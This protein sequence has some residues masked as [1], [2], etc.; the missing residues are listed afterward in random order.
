MGT[1]ISKEEKNNS[2]NT[3]HE[4]K[5][6]QSTTDI[7]KIPSVFVNKDLLNFVLTE[8]RVTKYDRKVYEVHG[9]FYAEDE[10]NEFGDITPFKIY[11]QK[12]SDSK[13]L[14]M[15]IKM[16]NHGYIINSTIFLSIVNFHTLMV[17]IDDY[18]N[19]FVCDKIIWKEDEDDHIRSDEH[20]INLDKYPPLEKFGLS[21]MRLKNEH[22][23]CGVCNTVLHKNYLETHSEEGSHC[24]KQTI[25]SLNAT[26]T[27]KRHKKVRRKKK[28]GGKQNNDNA[29]DIK[30]TD[31]NLI[32]NNVMSIM[33][34][35]N[36]DKKINNDEKTTRAE[37][38]NN[39]TNN[40]EAA[41]TEI[42][43]NDDNANG[44]NDCAMNKEINNDESYENTL[45]KSTVS[46]K[47]LNNVLEMSYYT[48]NMICISKASKSNTFYC[49]ACKIA[50]QLEKIEN[51]IVEKVHDDNLKRFKINH[52]YKDHVI[53]Q[54]DK[55]SH[56]GTCN[57]V[58]FLSG[59]D[60]HISKMHKSKKAVAEPLSSPES[61]L[62]NKQILKDKCLLS[63]T[64]NKNN[65]KTNIDANINDKI[66]AIINERHFVILCGYK[67]NISLM[68]LHV[69][70]R[71]VNGFYC[72]LCRI[73]FPFFYI[74]VHICNPM[75][76]LLLKSV[77]ALPQY[78]YNYIRLVNGLPHCGICHCVVQ[79]DLL[80]HHIQNAGHVILTNLALGK[81]MLQNFPTAAG[82]ETRLNNDVANINNDV[83]NINNDNEN[84]NND[85]GNI[86]N[87]VANINNDDENINNDV[88][89]INNDVDNINNVVANKIDDISKP[90]S[91][92]LNDNNNVSNMNNDATTINNDEIE[93]TQT[94]S[95]DDGNIVNDVLV[96]K[97]N[98]SGLAE[99][100]SNKDSKIDSADV[101]EIEVALGRS[102]ITLMSYH[103]MVPKGDGDRH[104]FLCRKNVEYDQVKNHI[105]SDLHMEN[106]KKHKFL[107]EYGENFIR[108]NTLLYHCAF[109]NTILRRADFKAHLNCT[110]H[111]NNKKLMSS[112]KKKQ[113]KKYICKAYE[114]QKECI[115]FREKETDIKVTLSLCKT[116]D[117]SIEIL[118]QNEFDLPRKNDIETKSNASS[119]TT[120]TEP[121]ENLKKTQTYSSCLKA[122]MFTD[123][124]STSATNVN[125]NENSKQSGSNLSC[126]KESQII[127]DSLS[128]FITD[129]ESN[130]CEKVSE[131]VDSLS[132]STTDDSK[133]NLKHS[134]FKLSRQQFD[135]ED[136]MSTSNKKLKQKESLF[137]HKNEP[138]VN[139]SV[140]SSTQLMSNVNFKK[141]K[142]VI[143]KGYNLK[144]ALNWEAWHAI[145]KVRNTYQRCSHKCLLCR[146]LL[147]NK[148]DIY[149][150]VNSVKHTCNL[151]LPFMTEY[152]PDLLRQIDESTI[153]C[154]VC[155]TEIYNI[156]NINCHVSGQ[157]HKN[158]FKMFLTNS[159]DKTGCLEEV[160]VL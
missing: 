140:S 78:G 110:S 28:K 89:N 123:S 44:N 115:F 160:L 43:N 120:N 31:T 144:Y 131:I 148:K 147:N 96:E 101:F 56:C 60:E 82:I 93:N 142:L 104:C 20:Q 90:S 2:S 107:I 121:N 21:I 95:V 117:E 12:V 152:F 48:W 41:L 128:T 62:G 8:Q 11:A 9:Q 141:R 58:H 10:Y 30:N 42:E 139:A 103:A 13:K 151:R 3:D 34:I 19:C 111:E 155:N 59:I 145:S 1:E 124:L 22:G 55:F 154:V 84:I 36:D 6:I 61:H 25:A 118:K 149:N 32:N 119:S 76:L 70:F 158:N 86:N 125:S 49:M 71:Y 29:T 146:D 80:L 94:S 87:D 98:E 81:A 65:E 97:T 47:V 39:D 106:M 129:V 38:N 66:N 137:F 54:D 26:R 112:F 4:T 72:G 57:T 79:P 113:L 14:D 37:M 116:N 74:Q 130:E 85:V 108:Q 46:V 68:S 40:E 126:E 143:L 157:N 153:N 51:H 138:E 135:I 102:K 88:R 122:L 45:M 99:K 150:H 156:C 136:C 134:E 83:A 15:E 92:F 114:K 67:I 73:N 127:I 27:T 105:D 132:T 17:A 7:T 77:P 91:D 64:R 16:C 50:N 35:Q 75:H 52:I 133:E 24:D 18:L 100:F 69:I 53:R 33:E 5:Y 23:H 109:C 159:C 63:E